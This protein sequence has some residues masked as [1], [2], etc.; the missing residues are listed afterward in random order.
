LTRANVKAAEANAAASN[1]SIGTTTLDIRTGVEL[2]Y[3]ESVARGRLIE[4]SQAQS[5]AANAKSALAQAQSNEAV[6]LAN[7]RAAIGWLDPTRS[8]AVDPNWPVPSDQEPP[9]LGQ[10]VNT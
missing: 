10:L 5:R 6:A 7:L 2:A 9:D 4:V 8:P 3:L 1:A